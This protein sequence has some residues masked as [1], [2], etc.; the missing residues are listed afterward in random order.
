MKRR[1][2]LKALV[3]A[4]AAPLVVM[5]VRPEPVPI[6]KD[7]LSSANPYLSVNGEDLSEALLRFELRQPSRNTDSPL[8]YFRLHI[9]VDGRHVWPAGL[10]VVVFRHDRARPIG[11]TN[12]EFRF[13]EAR[14]MSCRN[15]QDRINL[16]R[17]RDG[18][19]HI[20]DGLATCKAEFLL[21]TYQR[22][23]SRPLC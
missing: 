13:R 21:E 3:A 17:D 2:F 14:L 12:P 5:W 1:G 16:G 8:G 9:E 10:N 6:R 20:V 23:T 7:I 19:P 18:R 4:P 15:D 22:S 11:V